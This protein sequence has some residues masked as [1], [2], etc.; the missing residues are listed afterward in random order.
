MGGKRIWGNKKSRLDL[1]DGRVLVKLE[2]LDLLAS[3]DVVD[4]P[5]VQV[6]GGAVHAL[7]HLEER[8]DT[9]EAYDDQRWLVDREQVTERRRGAN[10]RECA[11]VLVAAAA[12]RV[13]D[14][15]DRLLLDLVL[16]DDHHVN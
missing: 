14:G 2:S 1:V 4:E 10:P 8:L 11:H 12:A 16:L 6:E 13:A 5:R 15:I 7:T 9:L 3:A